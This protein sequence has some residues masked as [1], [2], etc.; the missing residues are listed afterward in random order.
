[1]TATIVGVG[2]DLV[3]IDRIAGVLERQGSRFVERILSAQERE[4]SGLLG[5]PADARSLAKY[6]AAKEAVAKAL[7]T[8]FRLGVSWK[9]IVVSRTELGAPTVSLSGAA[10]ARST[11]LGGRQVLLSLSDETDHVLAFAVLC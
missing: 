4:Q 10:Q 8:G 7:G 1:M 3:R 6:F 9:D 2:T 11:A 5:V